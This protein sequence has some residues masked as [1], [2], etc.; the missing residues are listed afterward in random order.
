MKNQ[1][2]AILLLTA[3]LY[4]TS[5][6]SCGDSSTE[7]TTDTTAVDVTTQEMTETEDSML[8]DNLPDD[9]DF[10]GAQI[11]ILARG[12]DDS[13]LEI[14]AE[15]DGDVVNDAIYTRNLSVEERLNVDLIPIRGEGWQ[16]Y[17]NDLTKLRASVNSGS[18]AYQIV[19]GF[20]QSIS[21]LAL[22]NVFCDL[23][24]YDYLDLEQVWWNQSTVESMRICD[25]LYFVTGDIGLITSLGGS[26]VLFANDVIMNNYDIAN[27]AE[28]VHNGTWTIDA[29]LTE[30]A[31]VYHDLDGN[32]VMD[33]MDLY[34][35]VI[36]H[37]V[38]AD[39]FAIGAGI[40]QIT[41]TEDNIPQ[42]TPQLDKMTTLLDKITPIF[43]ENSASVGAI[44]LNKG[45]GGG[46]HYEMFPEGKAMI[47]SA[48]L[49]FATTAAYRNAEDG[50]TILPYPKMDETQERYYV[51]GSNGASLWGIPTDV[52]TPEISAAVLEAMACASYNYVTPAYFETCLQTKMA[53]N[54]DTIAMLNIIRD[55]CYVDAEYLYKGLFSE[56][57]HTAQKILSG[58]KGAASWYESNQ[59]K[60]DKSVEK[61]IQSFKDL[62]S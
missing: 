10:S 44:V 48:E 52:T 51:N 5:L 34:G 37:R 15:N 57:C 26:Y 22:E 17:G 35:F 46:R 60:I 14:D 18:N 23:T 20:G 62:Q 13:Y 47:I 19:A 61:A 40:R 33:D 9:L 30:T 59:K 56:T 42:Y 3:A 11:S 1:T 16:T 53:R 4:S 8:H 27:L 31:K 6:A 32:G 28:M 54:E 21:S 38:Y 25:A 43:G 45:N 50:Y 39:Y 24:Q 2:L 55:G 49:S 36:D 12:N 41:L 29:M 7:Q 58:K